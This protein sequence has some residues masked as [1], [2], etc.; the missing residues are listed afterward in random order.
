[1]LGTYGTKIDVRRIQRTYT[2]LVMSEYVGS[3]TVVYS[4]KFPEVVN[5]FLF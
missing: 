2:L 5:G 1:M 4:T 3:H